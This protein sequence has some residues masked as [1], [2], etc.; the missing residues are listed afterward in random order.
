MQSARQVEVRTYQGCQLEI[1]DDGGDGWVVIIYIPGAPGRLR[2]HN[3]VPHGLE[4]LVQEAKDI[5]D[6]R[7]T[8]KL[9]PDYP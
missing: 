2:L 9:F 3:R 4:M 1:L 8:G 7:F 6:K 5:V